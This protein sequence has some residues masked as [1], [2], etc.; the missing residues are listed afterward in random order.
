MTASGPRPGLEGVDAGDEAPKGLRARIR[1]AARGLALLVTDP[2]SWSAR[3]YRREN[4]MHYAAVKK[5][6]WRR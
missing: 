3:R 1:A 4:T 5:D 2:Q 6:S